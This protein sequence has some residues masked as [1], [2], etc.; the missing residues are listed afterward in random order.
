[1]PPPERSHRLQHAVW[2]AP[3]PPN[4]Y[5]ERAVLAPREIAVRW[6]DNTD[7]PAGAQGGSTAHAASVTVGEAL[8]P[9]G[10]LWKGRLADWDPAQP[11]DLM[12]VTHY[13]ETPD[14]KARFV[15]REVRVSRYRQS[16]PAVVAG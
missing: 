9:G 11:Q 5:G 16:L 7:A 3:A 6:V 4:E 10:I 8:A 14:V 15:Q 1:M 2:W 13:G 12:V